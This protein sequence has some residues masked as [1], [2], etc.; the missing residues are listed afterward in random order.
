[1]YRTN[2]GKGVDRIMKKGHLVRKAICL[3]FVLLL[4]AVVSVGVFFG[5]KGYRMYRDAVSQMSITERVER[6]RE[7]EHF[8][9]YSELTD[10]YIDAV[11]SVEDRRF[12][13]HIGLDLIAIGRAFWVDIRT[14][15][16]QQ[17]G[18]TLTQQLAKNMIFT[19][20]KTIERKAAEV[21]AVLELEKEYSKEEILELYVN[22][23]F[24]GSGYNGVYDAAVGYFGKTPSELT[25]Y[26]AAMLAGVPNA[27]TLYSEVN[28]EMALQRVAQVLR[29]MVRNRVITQAKMDSML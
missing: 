6:I 23:A 19:Q 24:F 7:D 11:I 9:K 29:S 28:G 4:S 12:R 21:F 27:P 15:S 26:E 5:V 22:T 20:E 17:G 18:S 10:F 1:M 2:C 25:E 13:K 8:T 16:F 14:M 3:L